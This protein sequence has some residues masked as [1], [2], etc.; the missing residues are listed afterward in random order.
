MPILEPITV[1]SGMPG[2]GVS[3]TPEELKVDETEFPEGHSKDHLTEE[4]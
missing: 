4:R 1:A 3:P 2:G